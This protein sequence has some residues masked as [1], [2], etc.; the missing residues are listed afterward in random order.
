MRHHSWF[1]DLRISARALRAKPWFALIVVFVLAL[2]IGANVTLFAVINGLLLRPWPYERISELVEI[3]QAH[4]DLTASELNRAASFEGVGDLIPR[5]FAVA[6]NEGAKYVFGFRVTANLFSVL[7]VHAALGRVFEDGETYQPVAILSYEYW[8]QTSGDPKIVGQSITMDNEQRTIVGVLPPEFTLQVRDGGIFIPYAS[9]DGRLLG[10]LKSGVTLAQANAEV[11]GIQ[12]AKGVKA[13]R[14][15]RISVRP[16]TEAFRSIDAT[17]YIFLQGA[18][19]L[20]LLITCLNVANLLLVRGAARRREFAIR[21]AIGAGRARLVRQ[22]L[23]ES[24][25]SWRWPEAH[26]GS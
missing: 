23:T 14:D 7:G 12:A 16:L 21:A 19:G 10:R 17:V 5:N 15:H 9:P 25:L 20:V 4:H 24:A 3:G 6:G 2:G 13:D 11:T 22:L 1:D 26:S 8:R 18:V